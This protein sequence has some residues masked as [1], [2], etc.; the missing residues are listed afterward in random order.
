MRVDESGIY[1]YIYIYNLEF[2]FVPINR[3]RNTSR[4]YYL[5]FWSNLSLF[6]ETNQPSMIDFNLSLI[7]HI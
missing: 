6:S 2:I 7:N 5:D 4:P 1:I 3:V